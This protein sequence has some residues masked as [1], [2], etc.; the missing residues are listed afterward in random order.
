VDA[1]ITRRHR[2]FLAFVALAAGLSGVT[3]VALMMSGYKREAFALGLSVGLISAF[4]GTVRVLT[5]P[6]VD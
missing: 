6:V 4:T 1:P 2:N 5:R 3:S